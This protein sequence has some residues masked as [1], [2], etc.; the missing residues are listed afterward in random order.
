MS[1]LQF[2]CIA[3]LTPH[4][5][6]TNGAVQLVNGATS[7]QGRIEICINQVWGTVCDDGWDELDGNVVCKQ[8]GYQ[9]FGKKCKT[10]LQCI[11]PCDV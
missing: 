10:I 7:N 11:M 5:N 2:N 6:C 4:F 3:T 1:T 9:P 8:L